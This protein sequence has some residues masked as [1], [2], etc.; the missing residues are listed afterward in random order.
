MVNRRCTLSGITVYTGSESLYG[1]RPDP[2]TSGFVV[3]RFR[4]CYPKFGS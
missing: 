3:P 1:E 4:P 2:A